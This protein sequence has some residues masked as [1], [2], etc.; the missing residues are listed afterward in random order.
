MFRV[1]GRVIGLLFRI[2]V[3]AN[4]TPKFSSPTA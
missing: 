3:A 1:A 4:L 2:V